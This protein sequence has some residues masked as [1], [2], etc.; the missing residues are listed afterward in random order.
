MTL[1]VGDYVTDTSA[2]GR[3]YKAVYCIT[4]FSFDRAIVRFVGNV[5]NGR[6]EYS[7]DQPVSHRTTADLRVWQ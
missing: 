6:I 2:S 7:R 4:G 1:K 5:V 3:Y